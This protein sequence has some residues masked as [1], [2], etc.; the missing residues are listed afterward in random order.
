MKKILFL[1]GMSLIL[2][3][4]STMGQSVSTNYTDY[5]G[6]WNGQDQAGTSYKIVMNSNWSIEVFQN[7]EPVLQ[8]LF[9]LNLAN[10]IAN[11][12]F[13]AIDIYQPYN[14]ANPG[15]QLTLVA[16]QNE[17]LVQAGILAYD[18]TELKIQLEKGTE[19]PSQFDSQIVLTLT[20]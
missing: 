20:K 16:N 10:S 13:G 2:I 1:V 5:F 12:G 18:G 11:S 17:V 8:G 4:G 6:T 19:R 9:K 3:S 15:N 14:V 7:G